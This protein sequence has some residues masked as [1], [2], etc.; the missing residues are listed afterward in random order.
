MKRGDIKWKKELTPNELYNELIEL[1]LFTN[2]ELILLTNIN[3]LSID[4]LND[5]IYSRFGYRDYNQ[6]ME[7]ESENNERVKKW[8]EWQLTLANH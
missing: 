8:Q 5:A 1:G 2:E 4:T 3:G 7:S 6:F